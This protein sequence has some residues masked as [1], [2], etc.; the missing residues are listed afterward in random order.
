MIKRLNWEFIPCGEFELY[1]KL[2]AKNNEV[3]VDVMHSY[4]SYET[5]KQ[6]VSK[7]KTEQHVYPCVYTITKDNTINLYYSSINSNG[8][9]GTPKIIWTNGMASQP[10]IDSDG[11]YGLTQFA[12]AIVDKP[13][14]LNNIK[15]AMHSDTFAKLMKLCY[16]SSGNRFDKKVLGCFKKDF[17]KEFI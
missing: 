3:R 5:R 11:V 15:T 14:T 4:S 9:F 2:I 16:M 6:W 12:Y 7:E 13:E 1:E 17:W 8:H 10:T